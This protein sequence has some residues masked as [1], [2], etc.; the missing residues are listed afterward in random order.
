[1]E[2]RYANGE[3]YDRRM[4]RWSAIHNTFKFFGLGRPP[5]MDLIEKSET[6]QNRIGLMNK[7]KNICLKN[8]LQPPKIDYSFGPKFDM[9]IKNFIDRYAQSF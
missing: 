1:M 6:W 5:K 8:E 9:K 7:L 3:R 2:I 4:E